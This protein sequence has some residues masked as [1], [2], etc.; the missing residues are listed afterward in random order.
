[1]VG[2]AVVRHLTR[3]EDEVT[4][5]GRSDLDIT[6]RD[7]V[8]HF[9][10]DGGFEALINCAAYTDVDGAESES[11]LCYEVNARGVGHLAEACRESSAS[12]VTIST[13]F[14]FDGTKDGF[15]TE[16]DAPSPRGVYAQAKY[17]GELLAREGHPE[18]IIVRSGW[19]FGRGG[20]NFLSVLPRLLGEGRDI[21]AI[22]DSF[23]TPTFG[24][25]L[26][27]ALRELAASGSKGVVHVVNSGEGESYSG[28]AAHVCSSGGFDPSKVAR[29]SS[30]ELERPAPRPAN[31]RLAT[32]RGGLFEPLPDWRDAVDRF[33]ESE[34][35]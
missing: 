15:Y 13:D 27:V 19:I 6:N 22:S 14:V 28:F 21:K 10:S 24:D 12:F 8:F 26:A 11:E 3:L 5:A 33:V 20:T 16:E 34:Q 32:V 30:A 4:A 23:G 9:V 35:R 17:E 7:A 25:D 2:R 18:C 1:M 31:S 29:V